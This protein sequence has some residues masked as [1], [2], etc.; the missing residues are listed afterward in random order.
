MRILLAFLLAP[1]LLAPVRLKDSSPG[2][3]IPPAKG[4]APESYSLPSAEPLITPTVILVSPTLVPAVTPTVSPSLNLPQ[5]PVVT[6]PVQQLP[7]GGVYIM[8]DL[9]S[10]TQAALCQR[11]LLLAKDLGMLSYEQ[12]RNPRVLRFSMAASVAI[13]EVTARKWP[14]LTA[15]VNATDDLPFF[16]PQRAEMKD[17]AE[18]VRSLCLRP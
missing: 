17:A 12:K 15:F 13:P 2:F 11:T 18:A 14:V 6:V 9:M 4:P 7:P 10:P 3:F 5:P 8:P 1:L 16:Q